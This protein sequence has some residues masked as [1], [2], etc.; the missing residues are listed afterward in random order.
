VPVR[1]DG[2]AALFVRPG[3]LGPGLIRVEPV[4]EGERAPAAR[5]GAIVVEQLLGEVSLAPGAPDTFV[6][7]TSLV[8]VSL[9]TRVGVS[10]TGSPYTFVIP[11][12]GGQL[13]VVGEVAPADLA[14]SK[15]DWRRRTRATIL[16]ICAVTILLCAGT[17][18]DVRRR[19]RDRRTVI[20]TTAA[21]VAALVAARALCWF[22]TAP[23][24][25]PRSPT[26]HSI[27]S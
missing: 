19:A 3:A 23:P 15:Q 24:A 9:S 7:A 26:A 10:P 22:A 25:P 14:A 16:S 6:L 27:F 2:P 5:L 1:I 12:S 21:M 8:P 11:S 4:L 13:L 17:L 20:I 18:I